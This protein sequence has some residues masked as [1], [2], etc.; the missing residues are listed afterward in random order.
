MGLSSSFSRWFYFTWF[1]LDKVLC[2]YCK[3][4]SRPIFLFQ[5][6]VKLDYKMLQRKDYMLCNILSLSPSIDLIGVRCII[7]FKFIRATTEYKCITRSLYREISFYLTNTKCQVLPE[8]LRIR[9]NMTTEIYIEM[10]KNCWMTNVTKRH[11]DR[12]TWYRHNMERPDGSGKFV[13]KVL[14]LSAN[15]RPI[16]SDCLFCISDCTQ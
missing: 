1:A 5:Q 16:Q 13:W 2:W 15:A 12:F 4:Q 7:V 14:H 10:N 6:D 9:E 8:E 11:G 3:F